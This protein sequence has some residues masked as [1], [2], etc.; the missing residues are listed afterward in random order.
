MSKR[1]A[2][3]GSYTTL[4]RTKLPHDFKTLMQLDTHIRE[5]SRMAKFLLNNI[6][7]IGLVSFDKVGFTHDLLELFFLIF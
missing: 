4:I 6:D 7:E 3:L 5:L 2:R 1:V